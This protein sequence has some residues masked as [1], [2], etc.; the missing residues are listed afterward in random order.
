MPNKNIKPVQIQSN[1]LFPVV[2]VG[3]SA[4]GLETFKELVK[5]IPEDSG[6]SYIFIQH[7]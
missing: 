6:M 4:G 3:A 7:L 2:G 5:A 1:N